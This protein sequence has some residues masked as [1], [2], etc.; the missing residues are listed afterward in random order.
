[1]YTRKLCNFRLPS[2]D[3]VNQV[4]KH[5]LNHHRIDLYQPDFLIVNKNMLYNSFDNEIDYKLNL[6][7]FIGS[8][9]L[10]RWT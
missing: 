9:C 10:S 3:I 1:M 2:F 4:R 7:A 6:T 8:P 5:N